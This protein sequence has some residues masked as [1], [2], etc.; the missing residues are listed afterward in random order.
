M[1]CLLKTTTGNKST[2]RKTHELLRSVW[3]KVEEDSKERKHIYP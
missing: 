2:Y 3:E 1:V